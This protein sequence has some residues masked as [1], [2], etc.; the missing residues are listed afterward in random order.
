MFDNR[1]LNYVQQKKTRILIPL[2]IKMTSLLTF[3][4]STPMEVKILKTHRVAL[5]LCGITPTVYKLNFV[6]GKE[7]NWRSLICILILKRRKYVYEEYWE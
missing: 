5:L 6:V 7:S 2:K 1:Q 3:R 4:L